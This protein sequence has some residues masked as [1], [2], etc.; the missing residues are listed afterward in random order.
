MIS[1]PKKRQKK[2]YNFPRKVNKNYKVVNNRLYYRYE[3]VNKKN[4]KYKGENV[5]KEHKNSLNLKNRIDEANNDNV[6]NIKKDHK[7][8]L[9][10][11][12]NIVIDNIVNDFSR[13]NLDQ[14]QIKKK[15]RDKFTKIRYKNNK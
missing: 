10:S 3:Y 4:L 9:D 14:I 11:D 12:D 7:E 6:N 15:R 13:I 1:N 5:N 8:N 2:R